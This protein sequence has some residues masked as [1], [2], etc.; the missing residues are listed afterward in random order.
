MSL[1]LIAGGLVADGFAF[2]RPQLHAV[3]LQ[4]LNEIVL[5]LD[6]C[7]LLDDEHGHQGIGR[8]ED[9]RE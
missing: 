5:L 6:G 4:N 9:D 7:S 1:G 2:H 8:D 3:A